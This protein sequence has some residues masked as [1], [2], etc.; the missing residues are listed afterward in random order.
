MAEPAYQELEEYVVPEGGIADFIV[1]DD[2]IDRM[3]REDAE[4]AFG[5]SGIANFQDIASRMADYGRYG[6]NTLA[7]VQTG[8]IVI[9]AA[10]IAENPT[11]KQS[12]FD[13]LR[14]RGIEDPERYVVGSS[15][16][17]INPVTGMP[18]FFLKKLFKG[19][20]KAFKKVGKFLKKAATVVLPIALSFT[21]LGPVF[22]SALGSGIASLINGG[23]LKDA[24]KSAAIAGATGG[25]L[26]GAST[27][28][29]GSGTFMGGVQ[30]AVSGFGGRVAQTASGLGSTLTG[31]GLTGAGN[32]FTGYVPTAGAA[33]AGAAAQPTLPPVEDAV[34][35]F[36]RAA[37]VA[38]QNLANTQQVS[39]ALDA[40]LQPLAGAGSVPGAPAT[41]FTP[42]AAGGPTGVSRVISMQPGET[43]Q[44][45]LARAGGGAST[46][47]RTL[48]SVQPFTTAPA[49]PSA[50]IGSISVPSATSGAG[51]A[52]V[53]Q[54]VAPT[55]T[56]GETLADA[57]QASR[58]AQ[59]GAGTTA[60]PLDSTLSAAPSAG[61]ATAPAQAQQSFIRKFVP[62]P[63]ESF[64]DDYLSPSRGMKSVTDLQQSDAFKLARAEGATYSEAMAA[65]AKELQPGLLQR[66][67]P[68][69]A[70]TGAGLYAGGFFETPEIPEI[71]IGPDYTSE[72]VL[73]E[74]AQEFYG[75]GGQ[76]YAVQYTPMQAPQMQYT[77]LPPQMIGAEGGEVYPRRNGGIMPYEGTPDEDSVR[78]LLMPGEFVMTKDAV[79]GLGNGSVDRGIKNMYSVMRDLESRGR[80]A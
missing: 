56:G 60:M 21:P 71:T 3:D 35:V 20:K 45:A 30:E 11:L 15:E 19:V 4:R 75:I 46:A 61:G 2:E 18:E 1:D 5:Q 48:A 65:A 77:P 50:G 80:V 17:S 44:Q 73:R 28:L 41:T 39:A 78:A 10:L 36:D 72:D 37:E 13:D 51:A 40:Q 29:S 69:A 25:I 7:H 54:A 49:A 58:A 57:V 32:L 9:P 59:A 42:G 52:G 43:V 22:G 66:Y 14:A 23:S 74:R 8:E 31:G 38:Q 55:P 47:R 34:P 12:I 6:D 70:L 24:F 62:D 68:L 76:P 67:G 79:R 33:G 26:K 64:Y 16:N 63:V 27:A 53:S